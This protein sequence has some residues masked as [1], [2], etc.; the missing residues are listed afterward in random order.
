MVVS[1]ERPGAASDKRPAPTAKLLTP[2]P[3]PRPC[4]A[5]TAAVVAVCGAEV[6]V[7]VDGAPAPLWECF[8]VKRGQ[9]LKVGELCDDAVAAIEVAEYGL[10]PTATRA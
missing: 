9:V 4:V 2:S 1:N 7:T 5:P 8:P 3:R 6:P 10:E